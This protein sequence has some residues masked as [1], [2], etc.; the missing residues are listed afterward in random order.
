M[1][2][3]NMEI[4]RQLFIVYFLFLETYP[5]THTVKQNICIRQ[6]NLNTGY[7]MDFFLGAIM[8]L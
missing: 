8:V 4:K 3:Q 1:V 2:I 5:N 6:G 7:L